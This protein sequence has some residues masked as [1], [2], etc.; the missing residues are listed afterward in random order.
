MRFGEVAIVD[1]LYGTA[2]NGLHIAPGADPIGAQGRKA[3]FH[4]AVESRIAPG[5]AG[6]INVDGL[7]YFHLAGRG[8]RGSETYLAE[9]DAEVGMESAGEVNLAGVGQLI[10]GR[11]RGRPSIVS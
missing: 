2:D 5:P 7:V 9:R 6:V 4:V 11:R 8:F 3:L 10:R 1:W